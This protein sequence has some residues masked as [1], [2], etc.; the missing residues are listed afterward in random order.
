LLFLDEQGV[1]MH[2][3][4]KTIRTPL[5]RVPFEELCPGDA[6]LQALQKAYR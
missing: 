1:E 2:A 5:S 4:A 3:A 6:A